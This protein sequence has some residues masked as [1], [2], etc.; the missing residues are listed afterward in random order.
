M[1][2]ITHLKEIDG[3]LW[4]QL[5]LDLNSKDQSVSIFTKSEVD[6]MKADVRKA[7]WEEIKEVCLVSIYDE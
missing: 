1:P 3:A 2:R 4:A 7:V 5:E 6:K